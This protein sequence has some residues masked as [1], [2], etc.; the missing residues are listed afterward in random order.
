[1]LGVYVDSMVAKDHASLK[2]A[3]DADLCILDVDSI[4]EISGALATFFPTYFTLIIYVIWQTCQIQLWEHS[5]SHGFVAAC[6][7]D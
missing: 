4:R 3:K 1:M 2:A 7:I 5:K 6:H